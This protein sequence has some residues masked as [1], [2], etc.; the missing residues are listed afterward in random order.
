MQEAEVY[1]KLTTVFR[2]IFDDDSIAVTP[3]TSANDIDGW[4]SANHV[5]LIHATEAA[6]KI[7]FSSRE[8]DEMATVGDMAVL[9][10]QRL[11][12]KVAN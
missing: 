10:Q 3:S 5:N 7:K 4:D 9:V 6:F 11:A 2:D 1:T 12:A 8:L